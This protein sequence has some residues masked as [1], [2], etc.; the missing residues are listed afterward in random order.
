MDS[1]KEAQRQIRLSLILIVIVFSIGVIGFSLI[2]RLRP[3]DALWLTTMTLTTVGYGD[4]YAESDLGHVFTIGLVLVG[5]GVVAFGLQAT[6]TFLVSPEIRNLREKR[7][8]LRSIRK[9]EKHHIICGNGELVDKTISYLLQSREM[10]M[11]FHDELLYGPLDNFLD[12]IFGDDE[13]GHYPRARAFIRSAY[14]M[15]ARLFTSF[16]TIVDFVVVVTDD[17]TYADRLRSDGFLVV[18]GASTSD[19]VLRDA[20]VDH[21]QALVVM[22]DDDTE[23]LLTVLTAR[24]YNPSLYI[25]AA[26]LEDEL[27]SKTLRVGANGVLQPYD[28]AGLFLN[29]VTLRP[30]VADYFYGILFDQTLNVQSTQIKLHEDCR[31]IGKRIGQLSLRERYNAGVIGLLLTTGEYVYAPSDDYILHNDEELIVVAPTESIKPMLQEAGER[32]EDRLI[33]GFQR[34]TFETPPLSSEKIYAEDET[35]AVI[36]DMSQ[37]YIVCGT[38][39]VARRASEKLDPERPFVI[40]SDD[41][42]Y[43]GEMVQR[44]FRVVHGDPTHDKTLK[45]AGVQR[46]LAIMISQDDEADAVL[47]VL[48]CRSLSTKLLITV[49]ANIDANIRKMRRAGADRVVSPLH[50]A[51]QFVLLSTT[52]PSVSAFFRYVLYNHQVQLET[53]ELYMQDDSP[54]IGSTIGDLRLDRLFRAGVIGVRKATGEF[55]YAPPRDYEIGRHEVLIIVTPMVHSD[56]LRLTAHGSQSKRPNTLRN[57]SVMETTLRE[58]PFDKR[59]RN[60]AVG[61]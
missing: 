36:D 4:V 59:V 46:A 13:H 25:T 20:G 43:T 35:Q 29:N 56:E 47:T 44:G 53:T 45:R 39:Q 12:R 54:W 55:V 3:L 5:F 48:T 22:L 58:N 32:I 33:T 57:T 15:F 26:T 9:M 51:A 17:Q 61:D 23:A 34:L 11:V 52:R 49:T 41:E 14:L 19:E 37:H 60:K 42:T 28:I 40:I 7:T 50:I 18:V 38:G 2:E 16:R 21:A 10:Y 24:S 8:T 6:A 31:W 30:A 1:F 27:G